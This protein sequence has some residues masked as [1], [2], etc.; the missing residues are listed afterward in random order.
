MAMKSSRA[1]AGVWLAAALVVVGEGVAMATPVKLSE[2][3][4]VRV[5]LL[6][7]LV[8]GSKK[9]GEEVRLEVVDDVLGPNREVLIAR[10][11]PAV[12]TIQRSSGRGMLGK[13]GKLE[14]T[15]DKTHA[16]DGTRVPLRA[17]EVS[18][19][20][21][22]AGAAITTAVLLAPAAV[23]V[24][25]RDVKMEK[26]REFIAFVDETVTIDPGK[27]GALSSN[28]AAGPPSQSSGKWFVF[29]MQNGDRF[30]GTL[31]ALQNG[32][33]TVTT[34]A[35]TLRVA[36]ADVVRMTERE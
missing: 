4:G 18:R 13:P 6:E 12:G 1:M 36:V 30:T 31:D 15:I 17:T 21:N 34:R 14:F 32:V 24:H 19:G 16:V 33:Y 7:T 26:G 25:G 23:L 35:G 2:R 22:N 5:R 8:S 20:R 9:K 10:G 11:T 29:E 27:S 3:A 28:G